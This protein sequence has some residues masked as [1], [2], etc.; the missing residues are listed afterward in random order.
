MS[1]SNAEQASLVDVGQPA[2]EGFRSRA[3][4]ACS[5]FIGVGRFSKGLALVAI[6]A[7]FVVP[8]LAQPTPVAADQPRDL[9]GLILGDSLGLCGFSKRLD[10]KFRADPRGK[11][12]FTYCTCGRYPLSWLNETPFA[13]IQ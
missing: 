1:T 2:R 4:G 8:S 3:L 7:S 9:T 11:S 6:A 13:D 12:V 5:R 10:Q